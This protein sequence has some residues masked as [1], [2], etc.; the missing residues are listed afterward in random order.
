MRSRLKKERSEHFNTRFVIEIRYPL[1]GTSIS[2][3]LLL[4]DTAQR[5]SVISVIAGLP[6][7]Q[8]AISFI[9]QLTILVGPYKKS[10][11]RSRQVLIPYKK[12]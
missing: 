3:K 11:G 7:Y 10:Q 1:D 2:T 6:T 4:S 9:K 5:I 12:F 8:L